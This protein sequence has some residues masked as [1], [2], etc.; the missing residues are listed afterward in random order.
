M[1]K[2][3]TE[4]AVFKNLLYKFST[5]VSGYAECHFSSIGSLYFI[6]P[7]TIKGNIVY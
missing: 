1:L 6:I 3:Q 4:F 2:V 7:I 5:I